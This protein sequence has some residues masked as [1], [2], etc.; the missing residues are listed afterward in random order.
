VIVDCH[1]H[2][3]E[4]SHLRAPFLEEVRGAGGASVDLSSDPETHRRGTEAADAVCV[5]AFWAPRI[6]VAV[7]NDY[8]AAYVS[9]EPERLIGY[10]S[11]DPTEE[12]A[13]AELERAAAEL[14]LSG[15]K[16][17]PTYQGYHPLD[18]RAFSVYER[19][20][21]LGLPVTL[22]MGTTP[23]PLA[24]LEYARPIHVDELARRFPELR[25]VIAHVAHPWEAEA[26]VVCRKHPHVY[27]DVS[28][29]MYRPFQLYHTLRLA[30]EYAV[31]R[32][33]LLGSD[34][35]WLTTEDAIA[36]LRRLG[37]AENGVGPPLPERALEELV[38]RD[39]LPLLGLRAA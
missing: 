14:G 35:P 27:A 18:E 28:A 37:S 36:G 16:L 17:G 31:D 11:V 23:H 38:H 20:Q 9:T 24:P 5:F 3:W 7:P 39:T 4:P 29:L 34:F 12:G 26:L 19:A 10:A 1:T 8:V 33:L 2:L 30:I 32:K 21:E 13:V 15:L 6:G 22:H 25:I